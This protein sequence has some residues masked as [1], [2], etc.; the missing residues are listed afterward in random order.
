[1]WTAIAILLAGTVAALSK[2]VLPEEKGPREITVSGST[3]FA[4]ASSPDG[5]TLFAGCNDGKL[6]SYDIKS[7]EKLA[8][9]KGHTKGVMCV[10]VSP[11][12]KMLASG[13]TDKTIRLWNAATGELLRACEGHKEGIRVVVFAPDGKTVLSGG[14]D[15]TVRLWDV[16]K[17]RQ[18]WSNEDIDGHAT[19]IALS[20]DG[21]RV[22]VTDAGEHAL[23]LDCETGRRL[24]RV[25]V[26][27]S[28]APDGGAISPDR[29]F[30]LFAE[31]GPEAV[32]MD[33]A[34]GEVGK[35]FGTGGHRHE[36]GFS[37][38]AFSPD[39]RQFA[40]G[41][42]DGYV[43]VWDIKAGKEAYGLKLGHEIYAVM[44]SR[45]GRY[46]LAGGESNKITITMW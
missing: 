36:D 29:R 22:F 37:S 14:Y 24:H 35:T 16:Q 5:E 26:K 32:L 34:T 12:G 10:A 28:V 43:R 6:E 1:M 38:L 20:K 15:D 31:W 41:G 9:F 17:G 18:V 25:D 21:K 46:V 39:G 8:L 2:E 23:I 40:S 11:D 13:S 3:V 19:D 30:A 42:H 27:D 44:Y 33:I 7:G 45:D 4:M